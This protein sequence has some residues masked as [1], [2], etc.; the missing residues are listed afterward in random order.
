MSDETTPVE[1]SSGRVTA[2]TFGAFLVG[3]GVGGSLA[4]V[5]TK[6][7][8]ELKYR[9][10]AD[11]EIA[12]MREHYQAKT[13]AL[14]NN[15][16]K[17]DLESIVAEK[18]Y[19]S[20][21]EGPPMAV[22]PPESVVIEEEDDSSVDED[23]IPSPDVEEE[24][25]IRSTFNPTEADR[26]EFQEQME[27]LKEPSPPYEDKWD[28]HEE[29]KTRSP[30]IPYVIHIDESNE[31]E[32]YQQVTLTYYDSDDVLC[33]ERD[34]IVD[35][36]A[37]RDRLV[38]E[39]NLNLFGHGS[40]QPDVVYI[41]NDRLEIVFEVCRSEGSFSE[42]VHGIRHENWDRGNLERMRVRERD[43]PEE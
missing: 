32:G 3:A 17:N 20:P 40:G 30:D 15:A 12:E 37:E 22:Q 42:E 8:L 26:R 39:R 11:D 28:Y 6:R 35:H 27:K 13:R 36:G 34:E 38:G 41:R 19:S 1:V 2:L 7:R 23:N 43:D 21:S 25:P 29:L 24:S 31:M 5:F 10:I 18:G 16:Q 33:N 14:E 4:Y 9:K